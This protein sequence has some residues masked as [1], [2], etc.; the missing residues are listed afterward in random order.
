MQKHSQL[1]ADLHCHTTASDGVLT[2]T[3]LVARAIEQGV[4]LLAITDHD[5]VD[6]LSEAWQAAAGRLTLVTGIELSS[7]WQGI[8]IH[9]V[10]LNFDP[11]LLAGAIQRQKE[12]RDIRNQTIAEKLEKKGVKNALE[13]ARRFAT[14]ESAL[15]RPQ[16]AK[17]LVSQGFFTSEADAFDKWLG[18]GKM[19]DVKTSWPD[20]QTVVG[21]ITHAGG[22]AVL[23]H[24]HHYRMTNRKLGR[25]VE[26]FKASGGAALEVCVSGMKP[27]Q[28]HYFASLCEK[29]DLMASRG[30]DFHTPDNPWVELGRIAPLPETVSPIWHAFSMTQPLS[31]PPVA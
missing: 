12:A 16:F 15:G 19:G 30:S 13:G 26:E 24:P 28:T 5:N 7:V 31:S 2:P 17:Y 23:A 27:E 6:G 25:L 14:N 8:G 1:N 29:Y 9:I 18:S 21:D 20:I 22:L 4:E 11:A 3:E 10:G